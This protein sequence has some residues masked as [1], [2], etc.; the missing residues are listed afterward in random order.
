RP[1]NNTRKSISLAGGRALYATGDIIGDI[2]QAH[3]NVS[4]GNWTETLG[5]V[6]TKLR[7]QFKN[8]TIVFNSS[9]GGDPEVEMFIF[10]CGGEFF[11]CNT[12]KLF[13]Y[14]FL[15]NG[16]G[17]NYST[18]N[19]TLQCRIK[20]IINRWQEVGKAMYAPPT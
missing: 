8:K 1:N 6:A 16:T 20:Q 17:Q 10:N 4:K 14:T 13:N 12:S 9:S 11:Y 7:E 18:G 5:Q 3:C 2:R 19:I 15:A